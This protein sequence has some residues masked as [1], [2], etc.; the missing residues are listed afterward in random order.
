MPTATRIRWTGA[1]WNP[2][3][4]CTKLSP[5]CDH[6]Y[7]YSLA[8]RYR[9]TA[10]YPVGFDTVYKPQKL[11]DPARWKDPR[12]IFVNSMSD[13]F[14]DDYTDDQL[15]AVFSVMYQVDR[16]TYQVLTK[17][18]TRMRDYVL[19]WLQ[20][21]GLPAV[22]AHIW[23]GTT[24]ELDQYTWRANRLREIP[25]PVR[26]IS[27]EPLLGPLPS[28]DLE[29]IGW[30]IIGGESGP[31]YR[32]LDHAWARAL[33]DR[34]R[35]HGTAVFFKQDSGHRTEMRPYLVEEDGSQSTIEEY[36]GT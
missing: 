29:G 31:G 25:V 21:T 17:R 6:C 33:R 8:E 16:H 19:E 2:M 35:Q 32:T 15:D 24:I 11:G 20:R 14:H 18:P 26:F 12:R 9:G 5:G 28:L 36:P 22:P 10:A 30:L 3:S 13:L 1:T 23:L 4:G 34:A 7:A 27:A